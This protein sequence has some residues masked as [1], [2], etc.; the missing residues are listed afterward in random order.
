MLR[1][2]ISLV[3]LTILITLNAFQSSAWGINE[4]IYSYL[5][6]V[7][8]G[9]VVVLFLLNSQSLYLYYSIIPILRIHLWCLVLTFFIFTILYFGSFDINFNYVRDLVLALIILL[10]GLNLNLTEKQYKFFVNIY[11]LLY[12]LAALSIVYKFASGFIIFNAYLP[13]PKN[14]LAPAYAVALIL[15]LFFG[16]KQSEKNRW[17]YFIFFPSLFAS[18]FVLRGRAAIIATIITIL[19][20]I[21]RFLKDKK[22]IILSFI[23]FGLILFFVRD[24]IYQSMFLN[25][26]ISNLNSVSSGR[27]DRIEKGIRF[28]SKNLFIGQLGNSNFNFGMTHNYILDNLISFGLIFSALI[29][30]I[31]FYYIIVIVKTFKR[32]SHLYFESGPLVMT[33]LVIISFFEYTYP[34]SPGSATFFPF[35]LMGQYLKN[36]V[37]TDISRIQS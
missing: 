25:Y 1:Q 26:D 3:I 5:R 10:I 23:L 30:Y 37:K 31:Y 13:V 18:L 24:F 22:Y 12:T 17:I 9:S 4:E 36:T 7:N 32:N 33:I 14:Q 35:L 15:S 21:F 8:I 6:L 2:S 29:L 20:F 11:I 19:I 16:L 34:Y 28:L 27:M